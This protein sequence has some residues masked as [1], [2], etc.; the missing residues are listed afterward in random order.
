MTKK[1]PFNEEVISNMSVVFFKEFNQEKWEKLGERFQNVITL[2]DQQNF[3]YEVRRLAYNFDEIGHPLIISKGNPIEIWTAREEEYPLCSK[4]AKALLV[5]PHSTCPVE[6]VFSTMRD[7]RTPKRSRLSTEN[8]E[9]C[10]LNYQAFKSEDVNLTSSMIRR[11]PDIWKQSLLKEEKEEVK[12]NEING[13]LKNPQSESQNQSEKIGSNAP[14]D[15]KEIQK[16]S[17][18]VQFVENSS[19]NSEKSSSEDDG[20]SEIEEEEERSKPKING[21]RK[22]E[23]P[24][25]TSPSDGKRIKKKLI[26]PTKSKVIKKKKELRKK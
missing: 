12:Q 15:S 1:L 23:Y 7:F 3:K 24:L 21:K 9:A 2:S 8:L 10:L 17:Q 4:L 16:E 14:Q 13:E 26:K 11:Y 22:S 5:L 20:V 18:K 25:P 19:N 6:R